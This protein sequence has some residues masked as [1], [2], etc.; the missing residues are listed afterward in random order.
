[1]GKTASVHNS[2]PVV[3][4][5]ENYKKIHQLK[6][7][8]VSLCFGLLLILPNLDQWLALSAGFKS[9]EKRILTPLPTFHFPHI[10]TYIAK[11][12]QY[13]KENF[14]WRNALF[15]YYSQWKYSVL[16]TSPLPEKV[17]LGQNGWFYPGNS[18]NKILN[19]HQGLSP[20]HTDTLASIAHH[21]SQLQHQFDEQGARLYVLVAPDSYSIYSENLPKYLPKILA[22]S[23]LDRF[24]SYMSQHTTIPVVDVRKALIAAKGKRMLYYQTDTHWNECGALVASMA[25]VDRLRQDF[26]LLPATRL[27]DFTIKPI[28]G[29]GGDLV[30]MLALN[31]EIID[32]ID[33]K[34]IPPK[35]LQTQNIETVDIENQLPYQRFVTSSPKLPKLL[36]IGDSF[37]F[38]MNTSLPSYFRESYL[39]RT[40]KCDMRLVRHEHPD[41]VVLEIVERNIDYLGQ[42]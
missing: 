12:N 21:L 35:S 30:T 26:P 37:S 32:P 14:G 20:I 38:A 19:Q 6:T 4:F 24:Q 2:I 8:L 33:Y 5:N 42:L 27:A 15:Y 28:R 40:H 1:M 17:L 23:N 39:V 10:Q 3:H 16:A 41:I 9:P 13:Y 36:L 18:L 34:I 7:A 22:L 31:R 11:F 25:L 29:V